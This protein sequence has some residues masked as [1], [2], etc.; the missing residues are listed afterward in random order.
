MKK[1]L[2]PIET[3]GDVFPIDG[4]QKSWTGLSFNDFGNMYVR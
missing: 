1:K 3:V 4:C 2:R